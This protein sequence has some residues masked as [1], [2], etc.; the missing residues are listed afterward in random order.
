VD[1]DRTRTGRRPIIADERVGTFHP[2]PAFFI[3][4]EPIE[5]ALQPDLSAFLSDFPV[6][7]ESPDY[8]I[9]DLTR[10]VRTAPSGPATQRQGAPGE[11]APPNEFLHHY[12]PSWRAIKRGMTRDAVLQTVGRPHR[13]VVRNDLKKPVESWFY[14][15]GDQFAIVFV[16]REVFVKAGSY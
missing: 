3:V 5:F 12:P 11:T 15:R 9:F 14:G 8:V 6:L 2:P 10:K 4:L 13:I 1:F 7:A 16:D